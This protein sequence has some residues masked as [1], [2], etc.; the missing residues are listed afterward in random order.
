ME[1]EPGR[2]CARRSCRRR[3][4]ASRMEDNER[5]EA[6]CGDR[7]NDGTRPIASSGKAEEEQQADEEETQTRKREEGKGIEARKVRCERCME[8]L[9]RS[10]TC[11]SGDGRGAWRCY[12]SSERRSALVAALC[13][14]RAQATRLEA[15][16]P[17]N[18]SAPLARKRKRN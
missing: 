11:P 3:L 1:V 9:C 5:F 7:R 13:R 6:R 15:S 2:R 16:S 17:R 14:R 18:T 10:K 4:R 8:W 12:S